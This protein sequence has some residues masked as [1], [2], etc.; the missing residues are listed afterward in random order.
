MP[1]ISSGGRNRLSMLKNRRRGAAVAGGATT[2]VSAGM[3]FRDAMQHVWLGMVDDLLLPG[4]PANHHAIDG[5]AWT[6]T[7][8]QTALVLRGKPACGGHLLHLS[9]TTPLQFDARTDRTAVAARA[10]EREL[11]PV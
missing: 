3:R 8:M 5:R 11:N 6:E 7:E 10:L 9:M 2:P 4:R 1:V